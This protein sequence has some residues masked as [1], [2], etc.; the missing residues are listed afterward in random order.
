MD[1]G[2]GAQVSGLRKA[3]A[4]LLTLLM[5]A[6]GYYLADRYGDLSMRPGEAMGDM[7]GMPMPG[8]RM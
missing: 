8:H 3:L 5:L 1:M 7:P 6:A 2:D 4:T